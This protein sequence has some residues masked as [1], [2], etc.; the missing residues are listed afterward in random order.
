MKLAEVSV[1]RHVF[2]YMMSGV[3]I[4]FGLISYQ[5]IGVDRFPAIDFPMLSVTTVLPGADPSVLDASVTNLI[6]SAVNSVSGIESIQSSSLP[7]ISAIR[8]QFV[9]EKDIDVAFNEVQAKVNQ[10]LQDLPKDTEPPVVSK[11]EVGGAPIMW[12]VLQGDR[13]LQQ[14]NRYARNRLKKRLETVSGV[15][16]VVIGGERRRTIRIEL[17]FERMAM[18]EIGV[19]EVVAA[20]GREHVKL[21]GGFL[22]SADREDQIKLDLEYHNLEALKTLIVAWRGDLPVRLHEIADVKDGLADERRFASYDGQRAVGLGIVRISNANSVAIIAEVKRRLDEEILPQLPPGMTIEIASDDSSFIVTIVN[23]LQEH[24]VEGTLLAA[25][26]VWLFLKSIRSTLIIATAIPVSL[27]G[28]VAAMYFAGYTFNIMTLLGLLL[29][30]GVVVDDA[31]VVLE[32]IH[33][34][35]EKDPGGDAQELAI[36]GTVQVMLPVLASTFTLVAIFASVVFMGGIIGRFIQPFAIIVTL[37]VLISTF[38][39]LTLTPMLCSRYLRPAPE[40]R[41]LYRFFEIAFRGMEAGYGRLL[42]VALRWRWTLILMTLAVVSTTGYFMGQL[43]KGFMPDEDES[44]FIVTLKTPLGSSIGYT[45]DRLRAIEEV[46]TAYPEIG[47]L[48]STIGTGALGRVNQGEIFVRLVPPEGRERRQSEVIAEIRERLAAIP[49][50]RAFASPVPVISGQRGEPLQFVLKGPDLLR[51]AALAE[52]LELRLRTIPEMGSMDM[53]LELAMPELRLLPDRAMA[54]DLGLSTY[55]LADALRVLGG[56]LDVAKYNDEPGDGERYDIRLKARE[57]SLQ[58]QEDL[59]RVY[60]RNREGELIRLDQVARF[61]PGLGAAVISR[62]NLQ[63]AATFFATPT[64]PEGDAA[65]IVLAEADQL[66]PPGYTI[67]LIGRAK[68][69]SKTVGYLVFA[70][71]TGTI[72]VYMVLASQFNSF[73]QPLIIMVA[74]PLAIAGGVFALW[75]VG[76]S[77]NIYSMIG[78]VLLVGLVAKNSILLIDFTNQLRWQG[79]RVQ[80]ALLQAC[81]VRMRPVLMTS[82]TMILALLPASLG[83]GAGSDTNGPLAV[84]VIGGMVSSTF[85]TLVVVPAVY[86]L[87]E[88]RKERRTSS[89][90]EAHLPAKQSEL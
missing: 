1:R 16:E 5:R 85:L 58:H 18:L 9:L 10:V 69:F 65:E 44:R 24:L 59:H 26:V 61:E 46:L 80:E 87:V 22:T 88:Q 42:R 6:E 75:L 41:G 17:D 72:L 63:Y 25:F 21:P 62:Y 4:L 36:G 34:R 7:G 90:V 33:R 11:V 52:K 74:Q 23:A 83:F 79:Y 56:G 86:S 66:L 45:R 77:L 29:L 37:G 32:N 78:L 8:I 43:G 60:L 89:S 38:V 31:I 82:F 19:Q 20:F 81:P 50:V 28:A 73:V 12:L 51:V 57:G 30:I 14:L 13:T 53:D 3:L 48:F 2:A 76:H 68:E 84:A 40:P 39:A 71:V 35:R 67:E 55:D 15:G 54:E 49:G 64:I 70:F 47:G 27:L